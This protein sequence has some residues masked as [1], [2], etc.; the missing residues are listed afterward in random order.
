ML[1]TVGFVP[2]TETG[3]ANVDSDT[4]DAVTDAAVVVVA[5]AAAV[6]VAFTGDQ[7]EN[8]GSNATVI[9]LASKTR[10]GAGDFIENPLLKH[11]R[12]SQNSGKN[13]VPPNCKDSGLLLQA[14]THLCLGHL[15][16]S[17]GGRHKY[18]HKEV[19]SC[20]FTTNAY[21]A[22]LCAGHHLNEQKKSEEE[23]NQ[24]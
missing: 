2:T 18:T 14:S 3:E 13:T 10:R 6:A 1:S 23:S 8:I 7:G 4:P 11:S 12:E 21:S 24:Q 5:V 22:T 20:W 15:G 19:I 9:T 16:V 17:L